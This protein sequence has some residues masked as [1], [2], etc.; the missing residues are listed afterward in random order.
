MKGSTIA[1]VMAKSAVTRTPIMMPEPMA[2]EAE[3]HLQVAKGLALRGGNPA[4]L[5]LVERVEE[6]L[7]PREQS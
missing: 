5:S 3:E 7:H 2:S 1:P 4:I 6:Q